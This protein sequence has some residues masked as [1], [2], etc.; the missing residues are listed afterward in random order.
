MLFHLPANLRL[1]VNE[2]LKFLNCMQSTVV[3]IFLEFFCFRL[4]RIMKA[5]VFIIHH[6]AICCC[7]G[8]RLCRELLLELPF[9]LPEMS[10]TC[11]CAFRTYCSSFALI[12]AVKMVCIY[13]FKLRALLTAT[14]I[15]SLLSAIRLTAIKS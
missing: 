6:L 8:W 3:I 14:E 11:C 1:A 12:S 2:K 7:T 13:F 10:H 5:T 4:Y 9:C 15:S